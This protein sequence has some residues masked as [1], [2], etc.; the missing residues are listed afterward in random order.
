[1]GFGLPNWVVAKNLPN[2]TLEEATFIEANLPYVLV[3]KMEEYEEKQARRNHNRAAPKL[4]ITYVKKKFGRAY[5][6]RLQTSKGNEYFL[7]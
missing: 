4:G 5:S 2:Q 7:G 6:K 1:M 3:N